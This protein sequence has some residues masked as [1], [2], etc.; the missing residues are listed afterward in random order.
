MKPSFFPRFLLFSVAFYAG[1]VVVVFLL[2]VVKTAVFYNLHFWSALL[3]WTRFDVLPVAV[4]EFVRSPVLGLLF[5]WLGSRTLNR[6]EIM[7]FAA[8][9]GILAYGLAFVF[10]VLATKSETLRQ[11]I[12]D[13]DLIQIGLLGLPIV[14]ILWSRIW[15]SRSCDAKVTIDQK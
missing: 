15:K 1:C 13:F 8:K 6:R 4:N 12:S 11:I 3:D 9:C 2:T 5:A 7:S 14:L 10:T